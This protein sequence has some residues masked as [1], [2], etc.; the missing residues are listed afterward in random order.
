M[1]LP[2]FVI[3]KVAAS[4]QILVGGTE[5]ETRRRNGPSSVRPFT[6]IPFGERL[7]FVRTGCGDQ[8]VIVTGWGCEAFDSGRRGTLT[9]AGAQSL[10]ALSSVWAKSAPPSRGRSSPAVPPPNGHAGRL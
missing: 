3:A 5:L 2:R 4:D 10:W 1:P 9:G 8:Y 7:G 6:A